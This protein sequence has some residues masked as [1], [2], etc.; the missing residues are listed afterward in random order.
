MIDK[1]LTKEQTKFL[2]DKYKSPLYVYDKNIIDSNIDDLLGLSTLSN[3]EINYAIKANSNIN[4][5][6]I[7]KERGLGVDST[8]FGEVFINKQAGFSNDKIYTVGNNFNIEELELLLAENIVISVDSLDQLETLGKLKP[9]YEKVMVRINPSFG[10]GANAQVITGGKNTKFG[11]DYE[12]FEKV[13]ALLY[14]YSLKLYGINQHIGSAYLE[15]EKLLRGVESLLKFIKTNNLNNLQFI[16]FG[17][18]FGLNYK[19]NINSE[20]MNFEK[21]RVAFD[22]IFTGFLNSYDNKEVRLGFEPGRY[23]VASSG[24]LIGTVNSVK[25]RDGKYIVG[26]DIGFNQMIRP[27]LYD[28]YHEVEILSKG[29]I[30][31]I[32]VVGNVCESGDYQCK[33]RMLNLP[34]VGDFVIVRDVGAYGYCL[35]SNYNSRLR[36]CEV[37]KDSEEFIVIRKRETLED[38]LL[39][40]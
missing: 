6:K 26:T 5:L 12:D 34:E 29:P 22:E 35:S 14:K 2:I 25:K 11:I 37:M 18:G 36:P 30:E 10:A 20:V 21:L 4:I 23:I 39:Q 15:H 40:Y 13:I 33:N 32:D 16:N 24:I 17:G 9:G 3:F 1:I 27:T 7:I 28:A 31:L 38:L 19:R 8:G